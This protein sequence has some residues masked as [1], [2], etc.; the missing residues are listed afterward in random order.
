MITWYDMRDKSV[1]KDFV[2]E[3]KYTLVG[4]N[5]KPDTLVIDLEF[6]KTLSGD[7]Q[8]ILKELIKPVKLTQREIISYNITDMLTLNKSGIT[9]LEICKKYKIGK[10]A[11]YQYLKTNGIKWKVNKPTM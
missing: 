11:L 4:T 1:R 3:D 9:T 10:T 6:A 5:G 2:H 8:A 7:V